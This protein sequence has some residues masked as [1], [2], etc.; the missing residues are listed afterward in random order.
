M[1]DPAFKKKSH[2]AI[3]KSASRRVNRRLREGFKVH[4]K[5]YFHGSYVGLKDFDVGMMC[6]EATVKRFWAFSEHVANSRLV[7]WDE[8]RRYLKYQANHSNASIETWDSNDFRFRFCVIQKPEHFSLVVDPLCPETEKVPLPL[9]NQI[10]RNHKT[11]DISRCP[12]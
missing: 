6:R 1:Y 3:Q 10:D 7:A 5:I 9:K 4:S 12:G 8:S 11:N 2:N